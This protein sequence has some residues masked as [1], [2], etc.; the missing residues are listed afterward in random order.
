MFHHGTL[1]GSPKLLLT[2][3]SDR[4][5]NQPLTVGLHLQRCIFRSAK[6]FQN[7]LLDD[8]PDVLPMAVRFFCI[9]LLIGVI[10]FV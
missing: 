3:G 9:T 4:L 7:W 8:D 2:R 10:T 6:Q 5:N 1:G